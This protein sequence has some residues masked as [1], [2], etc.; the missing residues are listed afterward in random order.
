MMVTCKT[1]GVNFNKSKCE[2]KKT[3][4]NYCSRSCSFVTD[5]VD[6]TCFSCG[7]VFKKQPCKI[8]KWGK[9]YCS[10]SCR[11][12]P[13]LSAKVLFNCENCGKEVTKYRSNFI[14]S[15]HHYCGQKCATEYQ[16]KSRKDKKEKCNLDLKKF[17]KTCN[18]CREEFYSRNLKKKFCTDLCKD[19]SREGIARLSKFGYIQLSGY[20]THPMSNNNG[21]ILEHRLVLSEYLGRMLNKNEIVHHI[22]GNRQD[23]RIDN[24]E[25]TTR[26]EHAVI[27]RMGLQGNSATKSGADNPNAK[28]TQ[29][30]A[31]EIRNL[32]FGGSYKVSSLAQKF[33]VSRPCISDIVHN[34]RY[35]KK[36]P[37]LP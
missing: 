22:N 7:E 33:Y 17:S 9:H 2:I 16:V 5:K 28:L 20:H 25:L 14:K 15:I 32:Y 29:E 26:S 24:L 30:Q 36:V 35:I 6:V 21:V 27:H 8:G 37:E 1:C 31:D 34:K 23:N 13:E 18:F 4:N 19:K 10:S 11:N 3:A 12:A